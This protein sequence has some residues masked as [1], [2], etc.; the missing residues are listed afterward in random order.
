MWKIVHDSVAGSS[1]QLAGTPCQDSCRVRQFQL[2]GTSA[3]IVACSDGA[4]S[5]KHSER[6]SALICEQFLKIAENE[7]TAG[8]KL[9]DLTRERA[10]QW[11][12]RIRD[13]MKVLGVQ[14]GC[15]LREL[16][17]TFLGAIVLT[18]HSCF[19][20]IG[21]G[22][23]VAQYDGLYEVVFWPQ[24][25]EYINTTNFLTDERFDTK[26]DFRFQPASQASGL[27]VFTD[28]LERLILQCS[29]RTVHIPFL[30]P[31]FQSLAVHDEEELTEP[32]RAF[33]CSPQVNDRT[34]D[35]KTLFLALRTSATADGNATD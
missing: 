30:E 24:S 27:A 7:L 22:A 34:D 11:C 18:E 17:A 29:D 15:E 19:F 1:H 6:G 8:L 2:G 25:G 9:E 21:D 35:D 32:M 16:A 12:G 31:L 13:E 5:A 23:M 33:L 14:V 4:G 3:L 10:V 28:G 20:Q 26:L